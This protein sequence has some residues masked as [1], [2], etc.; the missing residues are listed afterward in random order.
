MIGAVSILRKSPQDLDGSD[1]AQDSVVSATSRLCVEMASHGNH[2]RG[3][4]RRS[5]SAGEHV[6]QII[7]NQ[8]AAQLLR[9][10]GKPAS[11]LGIIVRE[12]ESRH[13]RLVWAAASHF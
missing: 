9:L 6:A 8:L 2:G 10:F 4:W 13:A 1:N 5:A 12:R 7:D 11:Y 3:V